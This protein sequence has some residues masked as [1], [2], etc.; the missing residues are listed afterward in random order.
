[1]RNNPKQL[2]ARLEALRRTI[3]EALNTVPDLEAE[4]QG[5]AFLESVVEEVRR[6]PGE[7]LLARLDARGLLDDLRLSALDRL[8][9]DYHH[10]PQ[11]LPEGLRY[12]TPQEVAD[13]AAV[14]DVIDAEHAA[15]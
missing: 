12:L 2:E 15:A 14:F 10:D 13:L 1:M 6:G 3:T 9:P 8:P 7:T 4:A 11:P 5:L